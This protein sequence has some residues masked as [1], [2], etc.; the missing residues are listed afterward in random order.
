[1]FYCGK[2]ASELKGGDQAEVGK[3]DL[4]RAE[5][6][7]KIESI[8]Y[9]NLVRMGENVARRPRGL[10]GRFGGAI[11]RSSTI[12][13]KSEYEEVSLSI[14][15]EGKVSVNSVI[16][17]KSILLM[18]GPHDS[19]LTMF[20]DEHKIS[21]IPESI[22]IHIKGVGFPNDEIAQQI[23]RDMVGKLLRIMFE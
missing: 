7:T 18:D 15:M 3:G 12:V 14:D 13:F 1:M 23:L 17:T 6:R 20:R 2:C 11:W 16:P 19:F 8:L 5:P 22:E 9:R 21:G 10:L 4:R